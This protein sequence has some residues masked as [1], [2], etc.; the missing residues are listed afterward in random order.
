[1]AGPKLKKVNAPTLLIVGGEDYVVID[2][3]RRALEELRTPAKKIEI[4]PGATHLFEEVG[5]LDEV[6]RLAVDWF[7]QYL[8]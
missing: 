3:N 8:H 1:M 4:V 7:I 2:L 6:S 5:A